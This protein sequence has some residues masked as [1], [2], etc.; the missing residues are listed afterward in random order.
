VGST[1]HFE[2][3]DTRPQIIDG[4][5]SEPT[6]SADSVNV[7]SNSGDAR[8]AA[9]APGPGHNCPVERLGNDAEFEQ[10]KVAWA[11]LSPDLKR[12]ILAIAAIAQSCNRPQK[13]PG[14]D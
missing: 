6:G 10:V 9:Q 13:R 14:G 3:I 2:S 11:D 5:I 4:T 8:V 7:G 1:P 12:S